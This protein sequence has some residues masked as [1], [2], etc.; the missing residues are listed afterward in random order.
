M[1]KVLEHGDLPEIKDSYKRAVTSVIL[2]NQEKAL[3]EDA[4]FL[5]ETP[6]PTN[7]TGAGIKT[8]IPS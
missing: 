1:A 4:A 6:A 8:G 5:S 7:N 3:K 2:E